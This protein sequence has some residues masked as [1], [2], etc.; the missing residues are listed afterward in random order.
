MRDMEVGS[1]TNNYVLDSYALLAYFL[2]EPAG[3]VVRSFLENGVHGEINL[4]LSVVNLGEVHYMA[5]KKRDQTKANRAIQILR[6]LPIT[7]VEVTEFR[8]L[9]A[10]E[11]K[12]QYSTSK[13]PF[14][15]ADAFAA[16]LANELQCPVITGDPEFQT[17]EALISVHWLPKQ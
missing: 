8:A 6:E 9:R 3:K 17:V 15:Y 10:A 5:W 7:F 12:A 13:R 14:S 1:A 11:I 16:A 4:Y 2:G